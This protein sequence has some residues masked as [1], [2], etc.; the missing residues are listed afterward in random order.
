MDL[1]IGFRS[2]L[3]SAH[4]TRFADRWSDATA[5]E[6]AFM[7]GMSRFHDPGRGQGLQQIRR[8]LHRW[9][10]KFYTRR[11]T[12]RLAHVPMWE[13]GTPWYEHLPYL[14]GAQICKI[15][16]KRT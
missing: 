9:G 2:S 1:G 15:H 6:S 5:L 14:P 16:I 13:G 3:T 7:H 4:A 8:N 12:P 11:D 10:G